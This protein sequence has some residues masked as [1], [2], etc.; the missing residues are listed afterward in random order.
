MVQWYRICLPIQEI[1]EISV[2][3]LCQEDPLGEEMATH[4]SILSMENSMDRRVW[5]VIAH[6]VA[7]S[8]TQLS[9]FHFLSCCILYES[10][11][12]L[13]NSL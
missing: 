11:L 13:Q 9:D 3:S 1:Q 12:V 8:W 7:K 5:R 4:S 2:P 6:G 10:F